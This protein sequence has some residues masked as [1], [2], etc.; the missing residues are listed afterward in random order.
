MMKIPLARTRGGEDE[1]E[2]EGE[3]EAFLLPCCWPKA[4]GADET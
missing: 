1:G 2:E 3:E 4:L